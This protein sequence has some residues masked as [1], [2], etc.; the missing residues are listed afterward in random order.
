PRCTRMSPRDNPLMPSHM[1]HVPGAFLDFLLRRR[2][3]QGT[4]RLN[5]C[6]G[7]VVW[8]VLAI[9]LRALR[10]LRA[11]PAIRP[12][13]FDLPAAVLLQFEPHVMV[14]EEGGRASRAHVRDRA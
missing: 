1:L 14:R 11:P 3:G 13:R 2:D 6:R 9:Q 8:A 10:S 7:A 5:A 12:C 4:R